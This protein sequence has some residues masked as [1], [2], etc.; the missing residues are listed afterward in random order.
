MHHQRLDQS[1]S[2]HSKLGS[3]YFNHN[4]KDK[5]LA[6]SKETMMQHKKAQTKDS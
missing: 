3:E 4:M 1:I 6:I 2:K 5:V